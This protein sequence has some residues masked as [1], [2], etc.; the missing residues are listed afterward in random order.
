MD[1]KGVSKKVL[2]GGVD[3]VCVADERG[4]EAY[5]GPVEAKD[6]N[7]GVFGKGG[8]DVEVV[9]CKGL[10][11]VSVGFF[12]VGWFCAGDAYVCAAAG[13]GGSISGLA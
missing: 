2:G 1:E 5:R 13:G 10:E 8:C 7:L 4:G 9:G 12:L 11:P 6:E 3:K